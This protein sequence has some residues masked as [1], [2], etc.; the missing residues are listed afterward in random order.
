MTSPFEY[1]C[2]TGRISAR[3][4]PWDKRALGFGT[5]E[6]LSIE[7]NAVG[8]E[9]LLER[10]EE[11]A[12]Q[13]GVRYVFGRLPAAS[14][15]MR[16]SMERAGYAM[17]ECSM[18]L[19]RDGF[20]GLP[21]VP[22]RMRPQFRAA[23]LDDLPALQSMARED[24][25]HGRFLEDPAISHEAAA[26]RTINWIGDLLDQGLLQAVELSG[27]LIGFHA[28]RLGLDAT[29]ADLI[30]TGAA[31]R[32]AMFSMPLWIGALNRLRD[33]NV[34]RCSTLVSAANVGVINLYARLGF[35]YDATLFGYRKF[36]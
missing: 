21:A 34:Q 15:T 17:I 22:T 10:V 19:S 32:Y 16:A 26:Q 23:T 14:R 7:A 29:H 20:A 8:A 9:L 1:Q 35:H 5:A 36:L 11:W 33:R 27:K 12:C 3:L 18:T 4:T 13:N 25:H 2:D 28:E 31:H 6:V 24:F 30:L